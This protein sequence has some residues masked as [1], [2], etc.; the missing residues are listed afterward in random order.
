LSGFGSLFAGPDECLL[1]LGLM[2][3]PGVPPPGGFTGGPLP[4][5]GGGVE[6]V[7]L[8]VV[9]VELVVGFVVDD[10]SVG[11][12]SSVTIGWLSVGSSVVVGVV[13]VSSGGSHSSATWL[14]RFATNSFMSDVNCSPV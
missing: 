1:P 3:P 14:P 6:V 4:G 11:V 2:P 8:V 5:G 13:V 7:L 12:V 9:L 10:V